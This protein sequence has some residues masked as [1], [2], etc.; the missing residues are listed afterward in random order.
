[1]AIDK[2]ALEQMFDNI[3]A[4]TDWNIDGPMLWGYFF[5]DQDPNLLKQLGEQLEQDGYRFVDIFAIES[6]EEDDAPDADDE[7]EEDDEE[8]YF[9]HVERV[10]THTV[11]SLELRNRNFDALAARF[12]VASYDGMDVGPPPN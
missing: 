2:A 3:R 10:E 12:G 1:M 11:W 4:E 7:D 6:D 9:L 8:L 5:T